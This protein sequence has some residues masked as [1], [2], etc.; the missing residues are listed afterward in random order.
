M[1][2]FSKINT[3][4]WHGVIR[5][6]QEKI[7]DKIP[8]NKTALQFILNFGIV[9]ALNFHFSLEL[10][11]NSCDKKIER[12]RSYKSS[13]ILMKINKERKNSFI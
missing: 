12:R 1:I 4:K 3:E 13:L 8:N 11:E 10:N 6:N 5:E 9:V 2:Y 7:I